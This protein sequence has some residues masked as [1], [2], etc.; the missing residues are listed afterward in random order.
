LVLDKNSSII[1]SDIAKNLRK[2]TFENITEPK[3]IKMEIIDR[4]KEE[5]KKNK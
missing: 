4:Q 1:F 3:R 2:M 5:A